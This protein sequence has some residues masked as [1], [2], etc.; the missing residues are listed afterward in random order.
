MLSEKLV[1]ALTEQVNKEWFS[2]YVY[3]DVQNYFESESLDGFSNWFDIQVQEERDHAKLFMQYLWDN[4]VKIQLKAIEAPN[5][6][7]KSYDQPLKAVLQH[8]QFITK[9]INDIYALAYEEKDFRTMQFLDW[10][11]KEQGE[12]EKNTEGLVKKFELFGNDP[13]GLYL[14]DAELAKRV[15]AAPSLVL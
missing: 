15:Y 9:S 10:F 12:E 4:G 6:N 7:F 1:N 11:V 13:K 8:E 2:A 3:L 14:L 5:T